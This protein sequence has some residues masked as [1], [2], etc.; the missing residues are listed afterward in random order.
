MANNQRWS[1][2]DDNFLRKNYKKQPTA[3]LAKKL[4]RTC[5]SLWKRVQMLGLADKTKRIDNWTSTEIDILK[6]NYQ[7]IG[8]KQTCKLLNRTRGAI[9]G[10][11]QSVGVQPKRGPKKGPRASKL[12]HKYGLTLGDY[13]RMFEQQNGVCAIC[14][15]PETKKHQSG[16]IIRL[17]VDH[18]HNTSEI[19]GLLCYKCNLLLGHAEDSIQVLKS[20]IKYLKRK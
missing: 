8:L 11:A 19:R 2:E 3:D 17:A 4:S 13:D 20:A 10:K 7:K 9:Q 5:H 1:K 6:N 15:Q 12:K 14:G 18:C 16:A